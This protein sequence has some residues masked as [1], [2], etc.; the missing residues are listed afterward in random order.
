MDLIKDGW[1]TELCDVS[2]QGLSLKV[3]EV[4]F[5]EKS[6]FQDVLVFKTPFYGTILVLDGYIQCTSKD[7][8]SYQENTAHVALFSH[9]NPKSVLVIGGGDGGV[10]REIAK[11]KGVEKIV[12][13]EIDQMVIDVSR[14]YLPGMT[15]SLDDPRCLVNV[16]DGLEFMRNHSNEFDVII[17][18]SSDPVGP[19]VELFQKPYYELIK[20]ALKPEGI[21]ASQG[22]DVW[23]SLP[24]ITAMMAFCREMFAVV[25]YCNYSI[26]S[27]MTGEIGILLCSKSPDTNF[28]NP[29]RVITDEEVEAMDLKYYNS[30]THV[31][32]F[33]HPQFVKK[34]IYGPNTT[35][36]P[37]NGV[38]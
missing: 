14:K 35:K 32:V 18:D 27:F 33:M 15:V 13:C 5:H 22:L 7:E 8:F 11:H 24:R 3:D 34:A 31:G 1:F 20:M 23:T 30:D 29:C 9:P 6:S 26:P 38:S 16:G 19:A 12:L 21:L 17:T 10:V 2:A 37:G 36:K 28:K 4:L 25:D